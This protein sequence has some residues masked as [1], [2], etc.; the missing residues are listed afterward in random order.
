[1]IRPEAFMSEK[2]GAAQPP[3]RFYKAVGTGA[4]KT[5]AAKDGFGVLL[6]GRAVRTPAGLA[7]TAPTEALARMLAD[8]WDAQGE[9][10]VM[11]SMPAVRLA[12]T[13]LD[14]VAG[15]REAVCA[16]AA[17]YAGSD[18]L[19]YFADGPTALVE[20][21]LQAWGSV[22]DWAEQALGLTLI[23]TVGVAPVEQPAASLLRA[24]RLAEQLDDFALAGLVHGAALFGSAVLAFALQRGQLSGE[25]AFELSRLDEA[26]QAEF[27]GVDDEAARRTEAMRAEA[28]MLEAWFGALR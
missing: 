15:A 20:R 19:C 3:R 28:A 6:D 21:Q 12:F 9:H 1:M 7:L 11:A 27:W 13:A 2:T 17:R 22:L 5:G 10:I 8:E 25:A 23:R 26:F 24:A 14:R 16:E 4:S 18:M